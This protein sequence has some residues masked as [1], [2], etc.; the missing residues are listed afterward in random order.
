V[1]RA[2]PAR[3]LGLAALAA[4]LLPA[5]CSNSSTSA[6][7]G[8]ADAS[9]DVA[10]TNACL[11]YAPSGSVCKGGAACGAGFINSQDY[12]CASSVQVCCTPVSDGGAGASDD[13]QV[14]VDSAVFDAAVGDARRDGQVDAGHDATVDAGQDAGHDAGHDAPADTGTKATEAGGDATHTPTEAAT[15]GGHAVERDGGTDGKAG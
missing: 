14:F 1:R 5:G 6:A 7:A 3:L 13:A 15:D 8:G 4:A 9:R 12:P 10:P 11:T 2:L